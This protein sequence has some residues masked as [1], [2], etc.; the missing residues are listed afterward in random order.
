MAYFKRTLE[1]AIKRMNASFP[2]VMVTGP[3]QVGKT[4]VLRNCDPDRRYVSLDKLELRILAQENPDLFLQRFPPPILIDEVHHAPQL[5]PYIKAIVDE[6]REKGLFWLTGSQQFRLMRGVSESLAGRVGILQLQGFSIDE[7]RGRPDVDKFVPTTQWIQKRTSNEDVMNYGEVFERIWRGSYPALYENPQMDW[8]DFYSSYI[9]T[10]IERDIRELINVG[11]EIPFTKFI[12]AVASRTGQLLNYSDIAKDIGK[13]VPTVQRWLSLLVASG[14]VYL[15]YPYA[16]SIGNRM[17]KM[18]K[19]Y[20]LDTGLACYL[21]RWS[22]PAVLEA[23]AKSGE[24]LE[25]FVVSE[26]LKTYWHNGRQPNFSFYRD[27]EKREIDL[28]VEDGGLL[29]PVEI[30]KTSNPTKSD[31][32]HFDILEKNGLNVGEGAVICLAQMQLPL[33]GMVHVL[34]LSCV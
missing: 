12:T 3:R 34:P 16:Q 10:Y 25:T 18:S 28:I 29:Y 2:V 31:I 20:F 15:L 33:T 9:Q 8:E 22:S 5:L 1:T 6:K 27:K 7:L 30:K 26:A 14:L 17:T 19:V 4:T 13:N 11:E 24:M 23:G 32:R 21:T